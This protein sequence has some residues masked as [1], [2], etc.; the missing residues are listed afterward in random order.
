MT[1]QCECECSDVATSTDSAGVPVCDECGEATYT[2]E[3]VFLCC[4]RG[5]GNTCP[6]CGQE[7]D[8]GHIQ[9]A[10]FQANW[11]EGT[12]GCTARKWTDTERGAGFP[13]QISYRP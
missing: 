7:I 12:C 2:P 13:G 5:I 8:W 10:Q 4:E 9:T 3:G 1:C 11:R 6:D